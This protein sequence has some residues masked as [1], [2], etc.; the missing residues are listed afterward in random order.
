[1]STKTSRPLGSTSGIRFEAV[2]GAGP[3]PSLD[4]VGDLLRRADDDAMAGAAAECPQQLAYGQIAAPREAYGALEHGVIGVG[5]QRQRIGQ[6]LV[7][8]EQGEID[9]E[10]VGCK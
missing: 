10:G 5:R 9:L 3:E 1:V 2:G 8:F 4:I 7:E 6:R